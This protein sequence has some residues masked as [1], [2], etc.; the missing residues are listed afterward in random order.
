MSDT[1]TSAEMRSLLK[2]MSNELKDSRHEN[3]THIAEVIGELQLDH[4][5]MRD[6]IVELQKNG[7]TLTNI[8]TNVEKAVDVMVMTLTKKCESIETE[9]R[10]FKRE[11]YALPSIKH[12]GVNDKRLN[13]LEGVT[14]TLAESNSAQNKILAQHGKW[15]FAG[16]VLF[17]ATQVVLKYLPL[18][19]SSN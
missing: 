2:E 17:L 11:V 7:V 8:C 10:D 19:V 14:K 9:L 3:N 18:F 4:K 16:W 12:A 13:D 15:F 6:T 5:D 1:L